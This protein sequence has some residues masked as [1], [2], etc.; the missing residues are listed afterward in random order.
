MATT[1]EGREIQNN[2]KSCKGVTI[3]PTSAVS[4]AYINLTGQKNSFS[5]PELLLRYGIGD[6]FELRLGWNYETG[7]EVVP[8]TGTIGGFFAANA[9][10]QMYSA[11]RKR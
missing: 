3:L 11:S 2:D 8:G 6:R 10:Q 1:W 9:E 4:C 5:F 7:R